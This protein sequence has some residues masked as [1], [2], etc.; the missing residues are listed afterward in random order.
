MLKSEGMISA[1]ELLP[2]CENPV[3]CSGQ[4]V[5][6]TAPLLGIQQQIATFR[7]VEGD[8]LMVKTDMI[9]QYPLA[10]VTRLEVIQGKRVSTR[11]VAGFGVLGLAAGAVMGS[12]GSYRIAES[13]G[14][15]GF[16]LRT[17]VPRCTLS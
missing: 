5:R 7:A 13:S 6:V 8:T 10:Q 11:R 14:A 4:R 16:V 2:A 3:G 12:V 1:T 15:R 17:R 9:W